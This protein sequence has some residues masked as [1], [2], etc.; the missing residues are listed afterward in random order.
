MNSLTL[1]VLI[2]AAFFYLDVFVI[3]DCIF[4][5]LFW[6]G[7]F[8]DLYICLML[9]DT[10]VHTRCER[11]RF[12]FHNYMFSSPDLT[13]CCF[14]SQMCLQ[15]NMVCHLSDYV[16]CLAK[17]WLQL[18]CKR[19]FIIHWKIE[20]SLMLLKVQDGIDSLLCINV[21]ICIFEVGVHF[22]LLFLSTYNNNNIYFACIASIHRNRAIEC[23]S[24][25]YACSSMR[26]DWQT[27]LSSLETCTILKWQKLE[28]WIL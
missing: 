14:N 23:I 2:G 10:R 8:G 12:P 24:V 9:L 26:V 27:N 4:S 16:W 1:T 18:L 28:A 5:A 15:Q 22:I 20:F 25:Y 19:A 13:K 21:L 3:L 6:K 11:C 7:Q 17:W